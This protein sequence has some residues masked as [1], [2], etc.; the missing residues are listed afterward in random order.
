MD[1]IENVAVGPARIAQ[2][3]HV[4]LAH[5]A[6]RKGELLGEFQHGVFRFA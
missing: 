2:S 3:L 4:R 1:D 6:W 5:I